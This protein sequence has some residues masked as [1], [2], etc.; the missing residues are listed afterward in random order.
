MSD[1]RRVSLA[2]DFQAVRHI[3][4]HVWNPV[5]VAGLPEDEYDTYVW[6]IVRLLREG[7]SDEALAEHFRDVELKYFSRDVDTAQ[8]KPVIE[9]LRAVSVSKEGE[10]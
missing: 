7:A 2:R 1:T 4:T 8:L 10:P 5:G 3:L 9:A 6:P